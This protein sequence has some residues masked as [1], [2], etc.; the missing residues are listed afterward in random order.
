MTHR[1]PLLPANRLLL[2]LTTALL[3]TPLSYAQVTL[4]GTIQFSTNSGGAFSENQSW[5]TFGGD[6]AWDLWV[7]RNPDASERSFGRPGWH[8][9][10]YGSGS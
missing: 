5:N 7:A 4:T 3:V 8:Q 6:E 2:C 9:H 10:T 1:I